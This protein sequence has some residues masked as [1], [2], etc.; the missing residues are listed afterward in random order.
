[1]ISKIVPVE[2]IVQMDVPVLTMIVQ[3]EVGFCAE[4]VRQRVETSDYYRR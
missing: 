2:K 4:Y 1:M 3:L